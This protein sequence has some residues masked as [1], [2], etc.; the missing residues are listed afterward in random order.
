LK[1]NGQKKNILVRI[2]SVR[3]RKKFYADFDGSIKK[4]LM[5][6]ISVIISVL[7]RSTSNTINLVSLLKITGCTIIY[8]GM[9]GEVVNNNL[10]NE[11]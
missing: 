9:R 5:D 10:N 7:N 3:H 8:S 11:D 2:K 1:K 4:I 6:F